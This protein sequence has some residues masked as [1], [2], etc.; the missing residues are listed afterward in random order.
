MD[1]FDIYL[2]H[3]QKEFNFDM[4]NIGERYT[5]QMFNESVAK[6]ADISYSFD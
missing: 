3:G 5:L 1:L 6:M 4:V 2:N